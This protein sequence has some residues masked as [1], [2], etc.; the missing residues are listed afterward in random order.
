MRRY[1]FYR[2]A[3]EDSHSDM[4]G[5]MFVWRF[6]RDFENH[7]ANDLAPERKT[8]A[9]IDRVRRPGRHV[10]LCVCCKCRAADASL[11]LYVLMTPFARRNAEARAECFVEMRY[12]IEAVT[13]GNL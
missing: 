5:K 7:F 9:L 11:L 12:I 8:L 1:Y 13:I 6:G 4:A 2:P 3:F 10:S